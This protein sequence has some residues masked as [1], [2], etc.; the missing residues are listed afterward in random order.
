MRPPAP[1]PLRQHRCDQIDSPDLCERKCLAEAGRENA[2]STP[3][4]EDSQ[5]PIAEFG[6][7]AFDDRPMCGAKQQPL[8]NASIVMLTPATELQGGLILIVGH[9]QS[10]FRHAGRC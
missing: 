3:N 10:L 2:S 8:K 7:D 5:R 9:R 1:A 4:V 6:H